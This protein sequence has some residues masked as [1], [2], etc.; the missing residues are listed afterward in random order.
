MS[1][2]IPIFSKASSGSRAFFVAEDARFFASPLS[3]GLADGLA[4]ALA[5][6]VAEPLADGAPPP[7]SVA[8]PHP[9]T[10]PTPTSAATAT[11][12][13]HDLMTPPLPPHTVWVRS[14]P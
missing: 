3:A 7:S 4:D 8:D 14:A 2:F 1:T 5:E 6:P 11:V 10:A 13:A 9:A 12:L